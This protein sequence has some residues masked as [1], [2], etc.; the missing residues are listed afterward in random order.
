MGSG[1]VERQYK[2]PHAGAL[3]KPKNDTL[4]L[5]LLKTPTE[6]YNTQTLVREEQSYAKNGGAVNQSQRILN[7]QIST[8]TV[9]IKRTNE[10]NE[11]QFTSNS[12]RRFQDGYTISWY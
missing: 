4:Q 12:T 11:S 3:F 5:A 7:Q 6:T 1:A 9:N 2:L 8:S 10:N